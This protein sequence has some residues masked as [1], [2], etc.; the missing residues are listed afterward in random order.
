[1]ADLR[2]KSWLKWG[3]VVFVAILAGVISPTPG[4]GLSGNLTRVAIIASAFGIILFVSRI[5]RTAGQ[6]S[7]PTSRIIVITVLLA[8]VLLA[9]A[10]LMPKLRSELSRHERVSEIV[11]S[12][13]DAGGGWG[14]PFL[15]LVIFL[16]IMLI[17]R[18]G[19]RR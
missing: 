16:T 13:V 15:M 6:I 2:N 17:R 11:G 10:S 14:I 1:M 3:I 12:L 8:A 5:W 19:L 18:R 9:L 7:F 4:S